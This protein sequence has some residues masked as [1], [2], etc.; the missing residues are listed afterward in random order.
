MFNKQDRIDAFDAELWTAMQAEEARQEEHVELIASEKLHQPAG[1]AGTGFRPDQ[2]VRGRLSG[3]A[4]L[5][6]L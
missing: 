5:R 1:H 4:L 2:Q 3:Q 6:W